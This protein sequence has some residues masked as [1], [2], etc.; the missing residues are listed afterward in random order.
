MWCWSDW[1]RWCGNQLVRFPDPPDWLSSQ[2]SNQTSDES[3]DKKIVVTKAQLEQREAR[4]LTHQQIAVRWKGTRLSCSAKA[5]MWWFHV[6]L[7]WRPSRYI[8]DLLEC[9]ICEFM[10][11]MKLCMVLGDPRLQG[12]C[13]SRQWCGL[14]LGHLRRTTPCNTLDTIQQ[15]V[16]PSLKRAFVDLKCTACRLPESENESGQAV[17]SNWW[18]PLYN[19]WA[20]ADKL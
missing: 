17:L 12:A 16:M 19:W 4:I 3:A 13:C 20:G 8:L 2:S 11:F 6:Y 18:A 5:R 15:Q 10:K 9:A 1:W 14:Y 7:T